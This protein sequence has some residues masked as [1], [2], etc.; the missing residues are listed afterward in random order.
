MQDRYSAD[1]GDFGKFQLLRYLFFNTSYSLCQ[2]W[3][4]YP[5]ES[6]NNDGKHINYFDKVKGFDE[7]LEIKFK[8]IINTKR[9]VK[10]LENAS[11]LQNIKY[12]NELITN[13]KDLYFRKSWFKNALDFSLN[14][15]FILTDADNGIATKCDKNKKIIKIL[16]YKDFNLRPNSGKYIFLDEIQALYQETSSLI[17]YHHLNRCFAHDLQI[18]ELNDVLQKDFSYV[19]AIKHKPYSP[20]VYFF[21]LDNLEKYEFIKQK[22]KIFEHDFSIHWKLFD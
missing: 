4:M 9:E 21:L 10:A 18:E 1:I 13:N 2:L 22:L 20:R 6:H 11:L 3:Y 12:F 8:E 19:L 16:D 17:V 5:D 14:S 15:D 7:E